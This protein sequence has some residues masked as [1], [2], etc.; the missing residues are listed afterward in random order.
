MDSDVKTKEFLEQWPALFR[1]S[2]APPGLG[3]PGAFIVRTSFRKENKAEAKPAPIDLSLNPDAPSFVPMSSMHSAVS[4]FRSSFQ[5]DR[6]SILSDASSTTNSFLDVPPEIDTDATTLMVKNVPAKYTQR[7]L[8]KEFREQGIK[9]GSYDFFYLPVDF[10]SRANLGYCFLNFR[11]PEQAQDFRATFHGYMPTRL[12]KRSKVFYICQAKVQGLPAN[13][14]SFRS[15]GVMGRSV[16]P[17]YQPMFF[18]ERGAE[19]SLAV[20]ES[21]AGNSVVDVLDQLV[22]PRLVD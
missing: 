4:S 15:S 2:V 14:E 19:V 6:S 11:K 1:V 8:L 18:D 5:S 12:N 21:T 10:K 3:A 7:M 9:A 16:A 20:V 17:E 22:G 13:V